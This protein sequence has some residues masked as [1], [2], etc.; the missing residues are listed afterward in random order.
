MLCL[1]RLKNILLSNN[2]YLVLILLVISFWLISLNNIIEIIIIFGLLIFF[3][4]F[5]IKYNIYYFLIYLALIILVIINL[6]FN[7]YFY[8]KEIN[9]HK[10]NNYF[11]EE[12]C[13]VINVCN[14][15]NYQKIEIKINKYYY[16]FYLFDEEINSS[17]K[18]G[19]IINIKGFLELPSENELDGCFNYKE[20]LYYD[21][22][23]GTIEIEDY[24]IINYV[25]HYNLLS[26]YIGE[27]YDLFFDDLS[28]SY[29]KALILGEKT[30]L[31]NSL[32]DNIN[33]IGIS[34]LFVVSGLHVS[35]IVLIIS[36]ICSKFKVNKSLEQILTIIILFIYLII[37]SFLISVIRVFLSQILKFLNKSLKLSA[38]NLFSINVIIVMILFPLK[39]FSLS[40]ILSYLISG[41]I[42]LSKKILMNKSYIKQMLLISLISTLV[43][44]PLVVNINGSINILSIFYNLLYIPLVT[45]I[46]LPFSIIVSFIPI[47]SFLYQ[48]VI[49]I[50]NY[51]INLNAFIKVGNLIFPSFNTIISL[52]YY[53]FL[54][55]ILNK[56]EIKKLFNNKRLIILF[57]I[58][59][60]L[61]KNINFLN[62]N[63]EISFLN[64]GLGDS[65]LIIYPN[66][67]L[68]ILI[69]TG[70]EEEILTYLKK[71]GISRIDYLIISHGD[72]DHMGQLVNIVKELKVKNIVIS[73][74]DYNTV[75]VINSLF[76]KPNVIIIKELGIYNLKEV[77]INVIS[78]IKNYNNTNDNSLVFIMNIDNF[79]I[80]FTGD[81]SSI[82]EK[83]IIN[84]Y[85]I[86]VDILKVAHHGSKYSSCI[87]FINNVN[88]KIGIAMNGYDNQ[89]GFPSSEV[90]ER[91]KGYTLLNTLDFKTI[92]FKKGIFEEKFYLKLKK[93]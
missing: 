12:R 22:I 43:T 4:Y 74:Y 13:Q 62:L 45:Y 61:F 81:I 86:N 29:L 31:D 58:F 6:L 89:F 82:V 84:K 40:F 90:I 57:S 72:S 60:L 50:F 25:F 54:Y 56:L 1:K 48:Y 16:Y 80:L 5:I 39:V 34:H 2:V 33:S 23:I 51:L 21:K 20:Y 77:S 38:F 8:N 53:I 28:S 19:T 15:N 63:I 9:T 64:V 47:L 37:T 85:K 70:E 17:I 93:T 26:Y 36:F 76:I 59:L 69:D 42:I 30:S 49:I 67:T 73:K 65:T 83:E 41:M 24:T 68:N 7:N 91:F 71:R 18:P 79:K 44:L 55:L 88:F 87:E 10:Q 66:N 11:I 27:Y 78:P 14:I 52:I 35:I 32:K 46:I 3:S 92:T 75:K